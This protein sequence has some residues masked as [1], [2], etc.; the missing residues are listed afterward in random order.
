M[1][2]FFGAV[3]HAESVFD[4]K[5]GRGDLAVF[6]RWNAVAGLAFWLTVGL[7]SL[8]AA[9]ALIGGMRASPRRLP[10]GATAALSIPVLLFVCGYAVLFLMS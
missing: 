3:W 4:S 10:R 5:S 6:E 8:A 2:V 7:W 1:A 9:C